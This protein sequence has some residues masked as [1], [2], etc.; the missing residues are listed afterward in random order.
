MDFKVQNGHSQ[1][2][3]S[4]KTLGWANSCESYASG[5]FWLL[6]CH[7]QGV[8]TSLAKRG[9]IILCSC[10]RLVWKGVNHVWPDIAST[11]NLHHDNA[12]C[13]TTMEQ[14]TRYSVATLILPLTTPPLRIYSTVTRTFGMILPNDFQ[15]PLVICKQVIPEVSDQ[16]GATLFENYYVLYN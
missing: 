1:S 3:S 15:K 6:W 12:P 5:C 16:K 13:N 10:V 11:W 2:P 7:S 8:F 14:L 9:W 4:K